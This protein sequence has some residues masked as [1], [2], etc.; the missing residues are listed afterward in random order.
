MGQL[1][2]A[3]QTDVFPGVLVMIFLGI[4]IIVAVIA[5]CYSLYRTAQ[6]KKQ[7]ELLD[8]RRNAEYLTWKEEVDTA[9]EIT[10]I[11]TSLILGADEE[12]L[13]AE[14]NVVLYE[15]RAVHHSSHNFGSMPIGKSG[16]RVGHGRSTSEST[17]EWRAIASGELYVTTKKIYFD[18]DKQD[19]KIP[20]N[21]VSTIKADYSAVEVSSASR[22]KSMVFQGVN[23]Q[24]VKE[25][26]MLIARG[27]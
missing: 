11:D 10:P 18:G 22:Q 27:A 23:G 15:V 13:W 26:V 9:N 25:I 8:A 5:Y 6:R 20:I 12:C 17:D 21:K 4:G 7:Q 16:I 19:R 24:I 1:L 14:R 2:D 3:S